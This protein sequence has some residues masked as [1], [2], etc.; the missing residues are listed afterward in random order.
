MQKI[1]QKIQQTKSS[2]TQAELYTITKQDLSQEFKVSL[3]SK[4]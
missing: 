2:N 1:L 4:N 3:M